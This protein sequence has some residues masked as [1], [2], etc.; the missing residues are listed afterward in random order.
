[1]SHLEMHS[2]YA[3]RPAQVM[4]IEDVPLVAAEIAATVEAGGGKV[5]ACAATAREAMDAAQQVDLDLL[6]SD[7]RLADNSDGIDASARIQAR[8]E[9]RVAFITASI[10]DETVARMRRLGPL[11]IL[12]KP[13]SEADILAVLDQVHVAICGVHESAGATRP[14]YCR[15]EGN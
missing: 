7:V 13:V 3:R 8:S 12:Q 9:V 11:A 14:N 6:L 1:M 2:N 5:V 15:A 10:D 4:I